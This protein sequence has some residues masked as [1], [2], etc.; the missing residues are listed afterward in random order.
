MCV[1]GGG[2]V[3]KPV[4]CQTLGSQEPET[5][6]SSQAG[7]SEGGSA[8]VATLDELDSW[9]PQSVRRDLTPRMC[10]LTSTYTLYHPPQKTINVIRNVFM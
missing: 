5:L 6:E 4:I 9:D 1:W 7:S 3:L 8:R 2:Y 10:P